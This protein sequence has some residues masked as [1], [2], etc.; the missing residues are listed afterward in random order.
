MSASGHNSG[1]GAVHT[2]RTVVTVSALLLIFLGGV[3]GMGDGFELLGQDVLE[4]FFAATSNPLMALMV[5]LL[6]TTLEQ[7]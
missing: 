1:A 4:G 3:G 7:S 2:L 5:G 6:A